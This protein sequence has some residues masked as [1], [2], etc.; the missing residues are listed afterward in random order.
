ME[1]SI[2]ATEDLPAFRAAVQS[3]V[4]VRN[5][6]APELAL[7]ILVYTLGWIWRSQVAVGVPTWYEMPEANHMHLTLAGYWY[8]FVS[9]PVFQF[10]SLRW[11]MRLTVWFRLL[12]QISGLNLHL[13]A[14]NPDRA[15][16]IGFLGKSSYAF[17][18]LLFAE[19]AL[20]AGSIST[21][22]AYEGQSVL[23]FKMMAAG[24]AVFFVLIILGPLVMF[25]P[26]LA[27]TRR[28]GAAEY[29]LLATRYVFGFEDKWIRACDPKTG[30]CQMPKTYER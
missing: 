29:G 5:S 12:W 20:L 11:Y 25:T 1:R 30:S 10:I 4:R 3:A 14:A 16:G 19:G 9:I 13:S 28:K 17:A 7:L 8:A 2:V 24:F 26:L 23:S 15:G 6:I 18:P 22:V 21:R 27:S